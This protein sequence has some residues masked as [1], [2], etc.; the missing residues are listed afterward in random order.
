MGNEV[1][2]SWL[3]TRGECPLEELV[4]TPAGDRDSCII[5]ICNK[6]IYIIFS[7][8]II[9]ILYLLTMHDHLLSCIINFNKIIYFSYFIFILHF[10]V[11]IFNILFFIYLF[12]YY[13]RLFALQ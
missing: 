5:I 4:G 9:Y 3:R 13:A 12:A 1:L 11:F 2:N 10:I 6:M 8:K 7:F